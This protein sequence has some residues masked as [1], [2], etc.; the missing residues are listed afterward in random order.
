MRC[1]K[2]QYTATLRLLGVAPRLLGAHGRRRGILCGHAH[3][4][5]SLSK[6][7]TKQAFG[8][9]STVNLQNVKEY[10]KW[11][12][13]QIKSLSHVNSESFVN[14]RAAVTVCPHPGMQMVTQYTSCTHIWIDDHY[15]VSKL[16]CTS[17]QSGLVPMTLA[18]V[19]RFSKFFHRRTLK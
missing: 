8:S 2:V 4:L 13:N 16:A 15:C 6:S 11:L 18:D 5:L 19:D 12:L 14:R 3:S 1:G 7:G 10:L 9:L 17:N